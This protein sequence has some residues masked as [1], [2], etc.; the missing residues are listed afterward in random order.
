M[1]VFVAPLHDDLVEYV[2]V[3]EMTLGSGHAR[4]AAP[5]TDEV[6]ATRSHPT[7]VRDFSVKFEP[8]GAG[9]PKTANAGALA[10]GRGG[11][12]TRAAD[13]VGHQAALGGLK[14]A[15]RYTEIHTIEKQLAQRVSSFF[16]ADVRLA[17]VHHES[18]KVCTVV[19]DARHVGTRK[20][21][22]ESTLRAARP[23]DFLLDCRLVTGPPDPRGQQ[24][25]SAHRGQSLR[26]RGG[27]VEEP[28]SLVVVV[29]DGGLSCENAKEG[30]T[31]ENNAHG[32][33]KKLHER[34]LSYFRKKFR[35]STEGG[36]S[37][38]THL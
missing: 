6:A 33:Q 30:R 4:E 37:P 11:S 13:G 14:L 28:R 27:V 32:N 25:F 31:C 15:I 23:Q 16:V 18:P 26:G 7:A 17:T 34:E 21:H 5:Q 3:E 1:H 20:A 35:V 2:E 10:V 36:P 9:A 12:R 19:R 8:P 38:K 22:A 29:H 24:V